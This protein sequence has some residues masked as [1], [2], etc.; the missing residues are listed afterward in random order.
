MR[1][2]E[3]FKEMWYWSF[4]VHMVCIIDGRKEVT[5]AVFSIWFLLLE[6]EFDNAHSNEHDDGRSIQYYLYTRIFNQVLPLHPHFTF[7]H[8]SCLESSSPPATT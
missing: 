7:S 6:F 3:E 5:I 4:D 1:V 2:L 8:L